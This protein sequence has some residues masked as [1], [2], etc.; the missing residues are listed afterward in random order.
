MHSELPGYAELHCL[1]AFSFQRGASIAEELF[2][3]AAGQGPQTR[4]GPAAEPCGWSI[5]AT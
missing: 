2:A 4:R 3:R 5:G 1:S